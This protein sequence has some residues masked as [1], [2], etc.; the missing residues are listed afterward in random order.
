M[1]VCVCLRAYVRVSQCVCVS[2]RMCMP[3][4]CLRAT[5][6]V[7]ITNIY[8]IVWVCSERGEA[9]VCVCVDVCVW[10]CEGEKKKD[11]RD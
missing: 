10:V 2:V 7:L 11:T 6:L 4:V 3:R 9:E 5:T 8:L 1:C